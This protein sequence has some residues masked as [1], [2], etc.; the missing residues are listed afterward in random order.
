MKKTQDLPKNVFKKYRQ[1]KKYLYF[2]LET[3]LKVTQSHVYLE[4]STPT[5]Y[6]WSCR[7][8]SNTLADGINQIGNDLLQSFQMITPDKLPNDSKCEIVRACISHARATHLLSLQDL[9]RVWSSKVNNYRVDAYF[10]NPQ[11]LGM[12]LPLNNNRRCFTVTLTVSGVWLKNHE[13]GSIITLSKISP[14]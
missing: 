14:D 6:G 5:N 11:D 2:G 7:L 13:M 4:S 10:T 12:C 9:E 1:D 3:P 8:H